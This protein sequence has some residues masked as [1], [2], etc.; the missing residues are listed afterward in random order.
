M[1][2][3]KDESTVEAIARAFTSNGRNEEEALLEVGYS[4]SYARSGL[5][6]R[7]YSNVLLKEAIARIDAKQAQIGQRTVE[8]LDEMYQAGFDI[9]KTQKNPTGMATN[10]TGIARLYGMD[11]DNDAG[12]GD[13]PTVLSAAD[14]EVFQ[15]M[16]DAAIRDKIKLNKGIA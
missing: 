5:G 14:A 12:K 16:A 10:T 3:I 6:N 11:K 7:V 9:A 8:S 2:N 4:K 13:T 1:P 15:A